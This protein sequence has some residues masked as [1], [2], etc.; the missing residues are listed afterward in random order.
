MKKEKFVLVTAPT[1]PG[2]PRQSIL[3][4]LRDAGLTPLVVRPDYPSQ[5][6][7]A[8][9]NLSSAIVVPGGHDLD[10]ALYGQ[11]P[12][13]ETKPAN[14]KWN[15]LELKL[16]LKAIH[17]RKPLLGICRGAQLIAV[18]VYWLTFPKPNESVLIQHLPNITTLN[19]EVDR[20]EDLVKNMHDVRIIPGTQM[21]EIYKY[22][23]MS[24]TSGHHQ[25]INQKVLQELSLVAGAFAP[26]GTIDE[27]EWGWPEQFILGT[28]FHPEVIPELAKPL[29]T[30]LA[31]EIEKYNSKF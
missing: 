16:L 13:P 25:A 22:S 19:H 9:Y 11:F 29:F 2:A 28:Q 23:T 26:D 27:V 30:R 17:G 18:G 4:C 31:E 1:V 21:A 15:L 20:Y 12:E 8:K 7:K 3:D 24:V 6:I 14:R 5:E 10:P